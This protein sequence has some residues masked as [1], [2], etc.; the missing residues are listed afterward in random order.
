MAGYEL[1]MEIKELIIIT[2]YIAVN[3]NSI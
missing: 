2:N 3:T 1:R